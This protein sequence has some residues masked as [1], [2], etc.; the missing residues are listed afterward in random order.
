LT[1]L[2]IGMPVPLSDPVYLPLSLYQ[3][4]I[5]CCALAGTG[6]RYEIAATVTVAPA[7]D[8]FMLRFPD[9][10]CGR[11]DANESAGQ[12]EFKRIRSGYSGILLRLTSGRD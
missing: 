7:I 2:P 9:C 11:F 10:C 6:T 12:V 4:V 3:Q 1:N 5:A 8:A